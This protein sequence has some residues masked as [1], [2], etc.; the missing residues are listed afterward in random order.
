[1]T[2][3]LGYKTIDGKQMISYTDPEQFAHG[4]A[5]IEARWE[6]WGFVDLKVRRI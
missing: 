6:G 1:M 5:G 2:P 3:M 4:M